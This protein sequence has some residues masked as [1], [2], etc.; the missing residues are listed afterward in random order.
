L[1]KTWLAISIHDFA[2]SHI[3]SIEKANMVVYPDNE[4][5]QECIIEK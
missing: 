2:K 4:R 5:L 1:S 3:A